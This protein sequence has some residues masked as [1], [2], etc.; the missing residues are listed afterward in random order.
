MT[1]PFYSVTWETFY[2]SDCLFSSIGLMKEN[3]TIPNCFVLF[4]STMD[5][6]F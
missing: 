1:Q 6:T 3:G 2:L 4:F 5:L